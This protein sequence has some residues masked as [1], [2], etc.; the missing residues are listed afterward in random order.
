M[1]S[2][3]STDIRI[4]D[5]AFGMESG[6]VLDFSNRTMSEFFALDLNVEIDDDRWAADGTSKGRRVK[7]FLRDVDNQLAANT[8]EALWRYR[9]AVGNQSLAELEGPVFEIVNRLRGKHSDASVEPTLSTKKPLLDALGRDLIALWGMPPHERGFAFERFLTS[10]FELY[11]LKPR[12]RFRQKG[13]EIDG[14]FELQG[15]A[16]LLEAKWH[17]APIGAADLHVFEGKLSQRAQWARGLFVSYTG[18]STEGL[19]AFGKGK[20]TI[21]MDGSDFDEMLSRQLPLDFVIQAK[22]RAAVETGQPYVNVRD[23]RI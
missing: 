16:Y 2:L 21:C 12:D 18:F 17:A 6:Y 11:G 7:R 4:L 14:S 5:K 13:E 1:S 23:L 10:T 20:R 9:T 19:Q 3:T 22:A 15:T 8:I